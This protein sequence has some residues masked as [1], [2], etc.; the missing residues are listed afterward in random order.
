MKHRY[1]GACGDF[2]VEVCDDGDGG[3]G[4]EKGAE[5]VGGSRAIVL[6]FGDYFRQVDVDQGK[7]GEDLGGSGVCLVG[8]T[9]PDSI[10]ATSN[11]VSWD[12]FGKKSPLG[13]G[14]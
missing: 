4:F 6:S 13:G 1:G 9:L 5:T 7:Q 14:S 8:V 12:S 11:V 10:L 3:V 2:F